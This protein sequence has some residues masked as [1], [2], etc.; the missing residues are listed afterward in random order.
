MPF[1][2]FVGLSVLIHVI[3][4]LVYKIFRLKPRKYVAVREKTFG[5][6]GNITYGFSLIITTVIF[7]VAFTSA[8]ILVKNSLND[9]NSTV[10]L[11]S[12][13]YTL[14]SMYLKA[15]A[16]VTPIIRTNDA[17]AEPAT[18]TI[19]CQQRFSELTGAY[20]NSLIQYLN[21]KG[22]SSSFTDRKN[23]AKWYW[24]QNYQGSYEQNLELFKIILIQL[25]ELPP[26]DSPLCKKV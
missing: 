6:R 21:A 10:Q 11:I 9:K 18:P 7:G 12:R 25:N 14:L 24:V 20:N 13:E 17:L 2:P 19:D 26:D 3:L 4:I 16:V 8:E 5:V 23:L 15:K 22:L 1:T